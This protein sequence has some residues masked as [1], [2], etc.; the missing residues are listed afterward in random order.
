MLLASSE[1]FAEDRAI[2]PVMHELVAHDKEGTPF[3][4][5]KFDVHSF[6]IESLP[7]LV[8][9][10]REAA[11]SADSWRGFEVGGAA[12][13]YDTDPENPRIE[14]FTAANYKQKI[15][16]E[17]RT[18][19]DVEDIPKVCAEMSLLLQAEMANYERIGAIV[20]AGTSKVS[21]I[22]EVTMVPTATLHPCGECRSA[23]KHSKL[24][25]AH[26]AIVTVGRD[27]KINMYQAQTIE[28]LDK[29][30]KKHKAHGIFTDAPAEPFVAA[31]WND[32]RELYQFIVKKRRL[33]GNV[34]DKDPR[35]EIKRRQLA[36][37]AITSALPD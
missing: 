6:I 24:T 22:A 21:K 27:D 15:R 3:D 12:L 19:Y 20:V 31:E 1:T 30:Y 10:A 29:R 4:F 13:A 14:L 2:G 8:C 11:Q 28:Q 33:G 34:Y 32:R 18:E 26:T 35:R 9:S 7:A 17:D 36:A 25:D 5:E 16:D 37:W 23:V